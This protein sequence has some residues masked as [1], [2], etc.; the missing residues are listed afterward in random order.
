MKQTLVL[1]IGSLLMGDDAIGVR[2]AETL[3]YRDKR[4]NIRYVSGETD[5]DYCMGEIRNSNDCVIIDGA[6]TG[7]EPCTVQTLDLKEVLEELRPAA[8]F[9]ETNLLHAMKREGLIKEGILVAVEISS[10]EFSTELSEP[11]KRRFDE[12]VETVSER[13]AA[14]IEEQRAL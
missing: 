11:I 12:L 13:I 3:G 8:F 4:E 2:I 6:C 5:V 10:V 7:N 14:Y 9:H 1:G